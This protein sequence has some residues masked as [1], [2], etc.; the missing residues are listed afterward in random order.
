MPPSSPLFAGFDLGTSNSA[1]AIFNGSDVQV[2]RN[3]AGGALTPSVVRIDGKGRITVGHKAVRHIER[4]PGNTRREFKRL[5]GTAET[6][7]FNDSK[8]SRLPEELSAEILRSLRK[9]VEDVTGILPARAVISVPALF[10]LPQSKATA[11]AAQLAGFEQV[12]LLQEPIAS[13]LAAGWNHDEPGSWMVYDLGGG[14]FDVSLLETRDGLLRIVGHDGDNYLGGRDFDRA[15]VDWIVA[16]LART[17]GVQIERKNPEH[18]AA[19]G[20]LRHAAEAAKIELSRSEEAEIILD[21]PVQ[22]GKDEVEVELNLDRTTLERICAPLVARTI[23]VCERLLSTNGLRH[24]Q[25]S[26]IVL[27]GGPSV[28]PVVRREIN[29]ALE[30]EVAAGYDPMT[31]VA[32]GAALFAATAG[33]N[34]KPSSKST[35]ANPEARKL[36]CQFPPVSADLEPYLIGK[37]ESDERALPAKIEIQRIAPDEAWTSESVTLDEENAFVVKA[38]LAPRAQNRFRI[39]A[40][41][42]DGSTIATEPDEFEIIQGLTMG[43]PPLSRSIGVALSD[44]SVHTYFERGTALPSRRTFRHNTVEAIAKGNAA[45]VLSIPIVQG[46]FE[47]AHLCQLVGSL[48]ISGEDATANIPSGSLVEMTLIVDRGGK[49]SATARVAVEGKEA[50]T[51]EGVAQLIMPDTTPESLEAN[52]RAARNRVS[53]ALS[54]AFRDHETALID[55]LNELDLRLGEVDGLLEALAGGD[56]DAGQRAARLILE[57]DAKL[58]EIDAEQSWPELEAEAH[59]SYSWAI[60]WCSDLGKESE[61]RLLERAGGALDRAIERRS[62]VEVMRQ[63]RIIR[64]I[65]GACYRRNP[66]SW[67]DDY[68]YCVSRIEETTDLP[69]AKELAARGDKAIAKNDTNALRS[70]V[71]EYWELLPSDPVVKRMSYDSGVR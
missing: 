51:F 6:L 34:A 29:K 59:G 11:Q 24:D 54:I 8:L 49:L 50:Q 38:K 37:F 41:A 12:E 20:V 31:L 57:V 69:K 15:V 36:W 62:V 33:L 26:R 44:D 43:D 67:V 13:A 30:T 14:T 64:R 39:I 47:Q 27:V 1:A 19:L 70:I 42:E 45:S 56:T 53:E 35:T 66:E 61:S 40:T 25:L 32:Q 60:L 7:D 52:L 46:E 16:E 17:E 5:M 18:S 58:S 28:M 63:L 4:D 68:H 10:E 2:V 22:V 48:Q 21:M 9:D 3:A 65:G 55:T 71:K 23:S